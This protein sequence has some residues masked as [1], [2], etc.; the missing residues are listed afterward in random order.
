[1][2][3]SRSVFASLGFT[4]VLATTAPPAQAQQPP[5]GQQTGRGSV[6]GVVTQAATG[7]PLEQVS[8]RLLGTSFGAVTNAQGRFTI[9]NISP[10]IYAMEA[11]RIGLAPNR[12]DD[13]RVVAGQPTTVNF[14]LAER[15]LVLSTVVTT[16][17]SDPTSGAKTPFS[18]GRISAAQMPVPATGDALASIA[19]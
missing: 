3:L 1:M 17:V 9:P 2:N 16:G 14:A 15:T 12:R 13:I 4:L 10:G 6:T 5:A 11:A 18:V 19:G 8:V 7:Q